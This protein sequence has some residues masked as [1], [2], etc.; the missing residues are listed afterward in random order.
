MSQPVLHVDDVRVDL[1]DLGGGVVRVLDGLSFRVFPG[2]TVAM[3]GQADSGKSSLVRVL[4]QLVP[5]T[6]GRV[7][8]G[9]VDLLHRYGR[10]RRLARQPLQWVSAPARQAFDPRWTLRRSLAEPLLIEGGPRSALERTARVEAL[11]QSL[12]LDPHVLDHVLDRLD[13]DTLGLLALVRALVPGPRLLVCDEPG[14][15]MS[16]EGRARL[17]GALKRVIHEQG[18]ACFLVTRDLEVAARLA[19]RVAILHGGRIVEIGP[20]GGLWEFPLHP[21][22]QALV[23]EI[24]RR[25][26]LS[27]PPRPRVVLAGEEPRDGRMPPGCA[28]LP[29]C[30]FGRA[31]PCAVEVPLLRRLAF[32][33]RVACH[34]AVPPEDPENS[35]DPRP[36]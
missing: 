6:R 35:Q 8:T 28:L 2:E 24:D 18:T 22:T 26:G 15:G 31:H 14:E 5:A 25:V 16:G 9:G 17:L 3:V 23:H 32:A 33:Q 19:D 4:F 10:E 30:P 29:R 36:S 11:L 7:V 12:D 20:T 34:L 13:E 21:L 27:G 1:P